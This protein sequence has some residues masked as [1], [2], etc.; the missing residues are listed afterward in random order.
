MKITRLEFEGTPE[1]F[2][3]VGPMFGGS[4]AGVSPQIGTIGAEI[5]PAKVEAGANIK[6]SPEVIERALTR[7]SLS[8]NQRQVLK[9]LLKV[10]D[11][12]LVSEEIADELGI[13]RQQLAGVFGA[14]GRRVASTNGWPTNGF[15]FDWE[16]DHERNQWRYFLPNAVR[17]VLQNGRVRL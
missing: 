8:D 17:E 16:W 14:L 3:K 9:A 5:D 13:T 7:R 2:H 10:G 6:I 1:E 11:K 15:L 4:G 12:G